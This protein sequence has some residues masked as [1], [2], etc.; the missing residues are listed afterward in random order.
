MVLLNIAARVEI[1]LTRLR[2]P[3]NPPELDGLADCLGRV[4][5]EEGALPVMDGLQLQIR[6]G[7]HVLGNEIEA[8][9]IPPSRY[10]KHRSLPGQRLEAQELI[11]SG[12]SYG[13]SVEPARGFAINF[14]G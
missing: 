12:C 3:E 8:A 5:S 11:D 2:S 10:A 1:T 9:S 6:N 14:D 7:K 13:P 4:G